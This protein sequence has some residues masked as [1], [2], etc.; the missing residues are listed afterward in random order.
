M[1]ERLLLSL[2]YCATA[3]ATNSSALLRSFQMVEQQSVAR[4]APLLALILA[5]STDETT[6]VATYPASLPE[7][8]AAGPNGAGPHNQLLQICSSGAAFTLITGK[9]DDVEA[10]R[11][12]AFCRRFRRVSAGGT[13]VGRRHANVL[14]AL[15]TQPVFSLAPQAL[16]AAEGA[17]RIVDADASPGVAS[18]VSAAAAATACQA[19][20]A[21]ASAAIRCSCSASTASSARGGGFGG[22][23]GVVPG[24]RESRE[25]RSSEALI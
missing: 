23:D 18:F 25:S 21:T 6:I 22:G 15:A 16:V 7:D 11:R 19:S 5:E 17:L 20:A 24:T 2:S 3:T 1:G 10:S 9:G 12:F 14:V 13:D 8:L 4:A